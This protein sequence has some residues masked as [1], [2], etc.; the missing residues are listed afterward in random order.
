MSVLPGKGARRVGAAL[1]VSL[2]G[3]TWATWAE[4][5]ETAPAILYSYTKVAVGN[6][7]Q[8]VL[9]PQAA[10]RTILPKGTALSTAVVNGVFKELRNDK[11]TTYG[12]TDLEVSPRDL[13]KGVVTVKIDKEREKYFP[14]ISSEVVYTLTQLGIEA[15]NFPGHSR[16]PMTR[17][18]VEFAAYRLTVP[19]WRAL[20]PT[21]IP[22]AS[23]IMPDGSELSDAQFASK[24]KAGD[25]QIVEL[26]KTY[27]GSKDER[28]VMVA[29]AA[30]PAMK[31]A[32]GAQL[33][34]PVLK[35]KNPDL[36]MA[37]LEGLSVYTD[38]AILDAIS[39][40]MDKD[41]DA[42]VALKASEV[43]GRSSNKKYAVRAQFFALRGEDEAASL[44]AIEALVKSKEATV[45]PELVTAARG[46]REKVAVAAINALAE[47]KVVGDLVA[48]FE[49]GKLAATRRVVAAAHVASLGDNGQRFKALSFQAAEG[50]ADVAVTALD[51]LAKFKEPAPRESLEAA[52]KHPEKDVRHKA[53]R[54]LSEV[55]DPASLPALADA[56]T[57]PEDEAVIEEVASN[58]MARLTLAEVLQYT[59]NRNIVLQRVAYLALGS[60][61][62]GGGG[63]GKVFEALT[64]GVKSKD[65]GIR[66][67]SARG[68]GAFKNDKAL[69][70]IM[71]MA[72]DTEAVVRRDVARALGNWPAGTQ[73]EAL[74]KL[75]A[76][77]EGDVVE[78]AAISIRMRVETDAYP[79]ILKL[80]RANHPH[81]GVRG[82]AYRALVVVAPEKEAQTVISVVGGGLFDK[83]R[84]VRLLSIRLLG[85]FEQ[86]SAVTTLA[87][88]L[89]DPLEENRVE[90]IKALGRT[91]SAEA[92]ELVATVVGDQSKPVRL[93][94]M[95]ALGEIGSKKGADAI[96]KQLATES[97]IDVIKAGE[98]AM[99]KL[100]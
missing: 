3:L 77:K 55:R 53:A 49:D 35:D 19:A 17:A 52:L 72:N 56:G 89:N 98:A 99:R 4:A 9:V 32:D 60:K 69:A 79:Q 81:A 7:I 93:A 28:V 62:S 97:D 64:K 21:A 25:P 2:V 68:L 87:A 24:I 63:G 18:D 83:D 31:L 42:K 50:K 6:D 30:I 46:K 45:A 92:V 39:D 51:A 27:L 26:I 13:E 15:V 22:A 34:L 48:L 10:R 96:K 8:Y 12:N 40:V 20:P 94:A 71:E 16:K 100:K 88:L 95:E 36:R 33:L 82:A 74:L 75:L 11:A 61:I 58:I 1:L 90:S 44:A 76:D 23:I 59:T 91:K 43:L 66:G 37:A 5:Q 84:D 78:A 70:A 41:K 29:M 38:D 67:A 65:G 57:R 54:L 47:L 85:Q 14:I 86:T 73:T 80:S